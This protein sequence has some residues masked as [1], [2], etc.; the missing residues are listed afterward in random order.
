MIDEM[1]YRGMGVSLSEICDVINE[2]HGE[3]LISNKEVKLYMVERF[4]DKIK[5]QIPEQKK[6][7]FDGF[8]CNTLCRRY[9]EIGS[10]RHLYT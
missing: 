8:C 10:L 1:I 9:N 4:Q 3:D 5:F 2:K 6:I 7:I